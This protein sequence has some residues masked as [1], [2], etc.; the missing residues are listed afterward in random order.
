MKPSN[1]WNSSKTLTYFA[2]NSWLKFASFLT[3]Q[4]VQL[5]FRATRYA[6]MLKISKLNKVITGYYITPIVDS[7]PKSFKGL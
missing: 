1:Y 3:Y 7:V 5:S 4:D 6:Y 2:S